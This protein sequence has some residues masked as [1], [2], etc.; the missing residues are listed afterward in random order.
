MEDIHS[1]FMEDIH[2]RLFKE[3]QY[4]IHKCLEL[5]SE[6]QLWYKHNEN[7]NSIGNLI[8]H[9]CGNVTQYIC[10]GILREKDIRKRDSEFLESGNY[11]KSE[12]LSHLDRTMT[13]IQTK[14]SLVTS[15]MLIKKYPVQGFLES[16]VGILVHVTE[17]FSYHV[18]Q[19]TYLTKFLNDVDT[20]FYAGK[21]LN[22]KSS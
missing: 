21:N 15:D 9:L 14:L 4:R 18:G 19:I 11:N 8:L 6:D 22:A 13:N 20:G 12:I 16:G 2:R 5:I 3:N 7:V 17:H 10:A 1:L